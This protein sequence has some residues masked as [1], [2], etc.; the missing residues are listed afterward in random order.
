MWQ[1]FILRLKI[2]RLSN[3]IITIEG[4]IMTYRADMKIMND[5]YYAGR[6]DVKEFTESWCGE[7]YWKIAACHRLKCIFQ[8]RLMAVVGKS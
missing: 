6:G 1:R 2:C 8:K 4:N 5:L 7:A 3:M